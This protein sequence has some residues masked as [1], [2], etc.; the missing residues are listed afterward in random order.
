VQF[1]PAGKKASAAAGRDYKEGRELAD[2]KAFLA[3]NAKSAS[4]DEL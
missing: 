4:H 2:F 3:S 1:F